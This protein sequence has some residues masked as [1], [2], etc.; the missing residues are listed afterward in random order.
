ME[1]CEKLVRL[2]KTK[3]MTQDDLA[4]ALHISRQAVYK[5]ECGQSYPEA[6]KLVALKELFGISIDLLLDPTYEVP[7][8]VHA[9]AKRSERAGVDTASPTIPDV[10]PTSAPEMV[11]IQS[12]AQTAPEL[13]EISQTPTE[14]PEKVDT[15]SVA[16]SAKPEETPVLPASEEQS[17]PA[18]S[19]T[20][21]TP[22]EPPRT[23]KR[24]FFARLFGRK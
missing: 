18:P 13:P 10:V 24:G 14:T 21:S 6:M 1:F 9:R 19:A 8:P 17:E 11:D 3:H 5:W 7:S 16:P 15:P 22:A 2:R 23:E 12:E 20:E 4:N